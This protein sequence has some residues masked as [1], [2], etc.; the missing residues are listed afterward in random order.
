MAL[1]SL[2]PSQYVFSYASIGL[3]ALN[4]Y[5]IEDKRSC[6]RTHTQCSSEVW[7][8][9]LPLES[10]TPPMSHSTPLSG[11]LIIKKVYSASFYIASVISG[12]NRY[13]LIYQFPFKLTA[14]L[15]VAWL[16]LSISRYVPLSGHS[17]VFEWRSQWCWIDTNIDHYIIFASL[18]SESTW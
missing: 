7:P 6:T 11:H 5:Q 1:C 18:K 15:H 13:M 16:T 9:T 3:P 2:C 12:E 4:T 14:A 8:T 17:D 10:S